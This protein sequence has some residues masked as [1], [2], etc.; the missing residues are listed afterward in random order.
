MGCSRLYVE[1]IGHS[2]VVKAGTLQI[3]SRKCLTT[4]DAITASI[5]MRDSAHGQ[6]SAW[7]TKMG[8]C[9]PGAVSSSKMWGNVVSGRNRMASHLRP[10]KLVG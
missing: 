5:S 8:D 9:Y 3:I 2:R 10:N 7:R 6:S 1:G 4:I